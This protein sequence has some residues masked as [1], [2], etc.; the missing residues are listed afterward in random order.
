MSAA[1]IAL[2]MLIIVSFILLP[3]SASA[4]GVGYC[5]TARSSTT[6]TNGTAAKPWPCSTSSNSNYARDTMC[7]LGGGTL[8]KIIN[9]GTQRSQYTIK[10]NPCRQI[11]VKKVNIVGSSTGVDLPAPYLLVGGLLLAGLLLLGGLAL[12]RPRPIA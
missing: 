6:G 1:R 12:R 8:Y 7:A 9:N 5:T 4:S 11:F 3:L 10:L 2:G